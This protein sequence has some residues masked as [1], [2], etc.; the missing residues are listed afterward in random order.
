MQ[1]CEQ[2]TVIRKWLDSYRNRTGGA[3]IFILVCFFVLSDYSQAESFPFRSLSIGQ[4]LPDVTLSDPENKKEL[5]LHSFAGKPLLIVFWG[6]DMAA[7]KK[8]AV[9]ILQ[10]VASLKDS[11]DSKGVSLLV[12]NLKN[13]TTQVISEVMTASGLE[14]PVYG[15]PGREA[16]G[17][18][19]IYVMPSVLLVDKQGKVVGGIGYSRD[20]TQRLRG[21]VDILLGDKSR[22]ELVAELNPETKE[23]PQELKLAQRHLNMGIVMKQKGMFDA[24]VRELLESL[25]LNPQ[26]ADARIELGCLYLEKGR[27]EDAIT[28]LEAGLESNPQSVEAQICLARISGELGELEEALQDLQA[29]TFR[30][31]RNPELHFVTGTLNEK[32]G[33]IGKAAAE[34]RKAYELLRREGLLSTS[35]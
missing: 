23:V 30:H 35:E 1:R 18:F 10:V 8:R 22:E 13:D 3:L 19:G 24:A 7:K 28:E 31:G 26:L 2:P 14:V 16:Y 32:K 4:Q 9:K 15:D 12:V 11:L 20:I 33:D 21:E 27:L 34:Y 17:R 5:S 6:G 29:L 25:E